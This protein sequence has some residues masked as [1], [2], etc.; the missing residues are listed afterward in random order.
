MA[1]LLVYTQNGALRHAVNSLVEDQHDVTI[2]DNRL[3][4][5]VC[6]TVIRDANLLI[7]ALPG[8]SEDIRW[9]YPKLKSR[10]I[11]HNVY[12]LA[13][14]SIIPSN[15]MKGFSLVTDILKLKLLCQAS[16]TRSPSFNMIG[17]QN[18]ILKRISGKISTDDLNFILTIYNNNCGR[19]ETLTKKENSKLYYIRKKLSLQNSIELKQLILLLSQKTF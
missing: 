11:E 7:D 5:L 9:L 4:F 15:Y 3:Q 6:A 10:G 19:R 2:F 17:I 8:N 1:Q 13:P 12:Y 18:I 14:P 16:G